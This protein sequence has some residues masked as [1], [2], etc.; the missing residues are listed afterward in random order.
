M[1]CS[2]PNNSHKAKVAEAT[3]SLTGCWAWGAQ[4]LGEWFAYG[5]AGQAGND[6]QELRSQADD[7]AN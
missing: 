4:S 3:Y 5:R 6:S 1:G 7:E 2:R